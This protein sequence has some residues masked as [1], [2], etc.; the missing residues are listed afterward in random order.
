MNNDSTAA[1][2]SN[3]YPTFEGELDARNLD[4]LRVPSLEQDEAAQELKE[5]PGLHTKEVTVEI[6]ER[7]I[8]ILVSFIPFS[9]LGVL[10]RLGV[11]ALETYVGSSVFPL[12]Y[13]QFIGCVIMGFTT[14]R[15][16]E[17]MRLSLPLHVGITTGFCGSTTTFSGWML[18]IYKALANS[19]GSPHAGGYNLLD[20][21]TNVLVTIAVSLIGLYLG[22]HLAD[23][24]MPPRQ[25]P[26]RA[27]IK[28]KAAM[29]AT[30]L[31]GLLCGS[32]IV[33][34]GL[35]MFLIV[36]KPEWRSTTYACLFA[37]FGTWLRYVF[38]T[39]LNGKRPSMLHLPPGFPLGTF[40]A[41][42]SGTIM[43]AIFFMLQHGRGI[44]PLPDSDGF[45]I[46]QGMQDGFCGCLTTVST[47]VVELT[48]A[49]N[50]ESDRRGSR[51]NAWIYGLASAIPGILLCIVIVGP[52]QW[53]RGLV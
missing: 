3:G 18:S 33:F 11:T 19:T 41:N 45:A 8:P 9:I 50:V 43:D 22:E 10:A 15:K 5:V 28:R 21:L 32:G 17:I 40:T 13:A 38:S 47:F 42:I 51:R 31:D 12:A 27:S 16:T 36:Y 23:L 25:P 35:T 49:F 29:P 34:I 1:N 48:S 24:F 4:E 37:P 6:E 26:L 30:A 44:G 46:L 53:T 39:F 14:A 7:L 20:A 2:R 52:V